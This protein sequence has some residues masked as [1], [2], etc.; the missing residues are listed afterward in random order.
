MYLAV[1]TRPDIAHVV[2]HK[3]WKRTLNSSQKGSQILERYT[4][5]GSYVF[6]IR[7]RIGRG[8]SVNDRRSYTGYVFKFANAAIS[9][10]SRKQR[11]VAL[12]TTEAEYMSISESFKEAIHLKRLLFTI[13]S[14]QG[15]VNIYNDNQDTGKLCKNPVFHNRTKHVDI[16][17]HFIRDTVERGDIN[18]EYLPTDEMPVDLLTKAL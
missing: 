15:P 12:S 16:R 10:E 8:A 18:I 6:L 4:K 1:S 13:L 14:F 7:L 17:H 9:R 5:L 3:F 11:T 2:Q